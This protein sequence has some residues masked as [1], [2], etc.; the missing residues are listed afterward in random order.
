M[1]LQFKQA[2]INDIQAIAEL[3]NRAY[4]PTGDIK[5]WTH[6]TNLISGERTNPEQIA[7]LFRTNSCILLAWDHEKMIACVHVEIADACAHIGMLATS[8]ESQGLGYGKQ[9]LAYVEAFASQHFSIEKFTMA[10]IL[11]RKELLAFYLRRG[12]IATEITHEYP[13]SAGV[14]FPK[15]TGLQVG[16]LEK[17]AN[18]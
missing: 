18:V 17:I 9:M 15:V 11:E 3:V 16:V 14:G 8:T 6:E 1:N 10:V 7:G 13:L 2:T 12:Y 4:R 5:G